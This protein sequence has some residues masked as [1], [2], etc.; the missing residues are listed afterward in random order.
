MTRYCY[1][2]L[3]LVVAAACQSDPD[4]DEEGTTPM[5]GG[6]VDSAS[7]DASARDASQDVQVG[8]A[9]SPASDVRL[10]CAAP[11]DGQC[12][13]D[14]Q[15]ITGF[16]WDSEGCRTADE[17]VTCLFGSGAQSLRG[18]FVRT[19]TSATYLVSEIGCMPPGWAPC[20]DEE[21]QAASDRDQLGS[22]QG[23][24]E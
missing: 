20:S 5:G 13:P 1:I 6:L 15:Q 24:P 16:T 11:M 3:V 14:S 17:I 10:A 19:D 8:D 2:G 12:P 4:S 9:A 7:N 23:C 22:A 21:N 18:C